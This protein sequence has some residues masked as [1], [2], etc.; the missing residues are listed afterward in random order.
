MSFWSK[1]KQS[2]WRIDVYSVIVKE[3][4]GNKENAV[5]E[6]E[7]NP[8]EV[9]DEAIPEEIVR[10][11]FFV[12][13]FVTTENQSFEKHTYSVLCVAMNPQRPGQILT[14]GQDNRAFLFNANE[15]EKVIELTGH[16]E[17]VCAVCFS[18]KG[19][20]CATIDMNGELK[21]WKTADGAPVLT[22][23][24]P[25]EPE[26][27]QFHPNVILQNNSELQGSV[28]LTSGNDFCVW[29]W[30]VTS[31]ESHPVCIK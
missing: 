31:G 5:E 24:G 27:L 13:Q 20:L 6:T 12:G 7:E 2:V 19:N 11:S 8:E 14:G 16:N 4:G 1:Q 25:E 10:D 26:W 30:L 17:S 15:P 9:E 23:Q 22:I 28:I 3:E 29:S 18:P 21:I